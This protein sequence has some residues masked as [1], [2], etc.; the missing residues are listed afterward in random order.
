MRRRLL[1]NTAR[2][3]FTW[4]GQVYE[5]FVNLS[6]YKFHSIRNRLGQYSLQLH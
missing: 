3:A 4:G 1:E 6:L 5:R 2:P